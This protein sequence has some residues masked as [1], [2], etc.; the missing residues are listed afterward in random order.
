MAT[1]IALVIEDDVDLA[2]IFSEAVRAAGYTVETI[3]DGLVAERRLKTIVPDLVFMDLHLP[4]LDGGELLNRIR[5]DHRLSGTFVIAAS[6]DAAF[7]DAVRKRANLT[8][9]KPVSYSQLN[10]MAQHIRARKERQCQP[11]HKIETKLGRGA[12]A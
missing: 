6:A 1:S 10:R 3:D 9:V 2:T 7:S 5:A 8:L 12:A 11:D 4:G